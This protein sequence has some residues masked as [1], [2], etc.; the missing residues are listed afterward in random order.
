MRVAQIGNFIPAHST[1][2]HLKR[3]L[4][5]NGNRVIPFQ[6]NYPAT[7]MPGE[8]LREEP[9][10]VLWTRTWHLP[11]FDQDGLLDACAAAGV[12][13]IAYH[14]DRW[15]DLDREHQIVEEPMFRCALVV[16]ADGG[17]ADEWAHAGVNHHWFP[18]GVLAAEA[19]VPG[20][21]RRQLAS[22]IAFVGSTGH[23]HPEW[24]WRLELIDWLRSTYGERV[25]FWPKPNQP[26]V[27][28][29]RL[30]DLYAS[31]KVAVGD[32]C[33]VPRADGTSMHHYWSDRVPETIGRGAIL[34]HPYVEGIVEAFTDDE[35]GLDRGPWTFPLGNFDALAE[36]I[37]RALGSWDVATGDQAWVL[38]HHSYERRMADLIELLH[39]EGLL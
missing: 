39:R 10:F 17:H 36:M 6:E 25:Q 18:P 2:N 24:P 33:L 1:E 34:V 11:E 12:P 26:A 15:W 16:T 32:S 30:N 7:W 9:D 5:I 19:S 20:Q 3:A 23:Y 31:V 37:D 27:R 4:E 38:E 21:Y 35:T 22:E 13:T 14:L 29:Q 8:V 28:G